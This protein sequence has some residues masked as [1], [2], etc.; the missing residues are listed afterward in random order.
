MIAV[1]GEALMDVVRNGAEAARPGG[2]PFNTARALARLGVPAAFIGRLSGDPAGVELRR[3]LASDGVDLSMS[4]VG[5]EPTTVALAEVDGSG[6]AS[7]RFEFAGTSAPNLTTAMLPAHLPTEVQ[8]LHVGSLG[9]LLEPMAAT[10]CELVR[11]ESGSKV[12]MVDPNIR[13]QAIDD[14]RAYRH[15]L[16]SVMAQ[17]TIVKAA[18]SDVAW[19]APGAGVE[20]F[21]TSVLNETG[22]RLAVVTLGAQGAFGVTPR[23]R[24]RVAAPQV[25]VADTIGAGDAFGAALLAWLHRRGLVVKDLN[26]DRSDLEDALTFACMVAS[27]ACARAGTPRRSELNLP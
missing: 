27:M 20:E 14:A 18:D 8:A 2:G 6:L 24:A 13:E 11:R 12:I 19:L 17:S 15:R 22:A 23:A 26:L 7:Y 21:A 3:C 5:P 9:L 4:A 10:I 1:A 25:S 16:E